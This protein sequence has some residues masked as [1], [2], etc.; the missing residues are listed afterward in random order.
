MVADGWTWKG[1]K[2]QI[3]IVTGLWC[4]CCILAL[5]YF[6]LT[7]K[8]QIEFKSLPMGR[9]TTAGA[10]SDPRT[11]SAVF[12]FEEFVPWE[13]R[14][15]LAASSTGRRRLPSLFSSS[16]KSKQWKPAPTLNGR[17]YVVGHV[18]QITNFRELEFE[19]LLQA[20]SP[21]KVISLASQ[22]RSGMTPS[23]A[24]PRTTMMTIPQGDTLDTPRPSI[25]N[26]PHSTPAKKGQ[27][28]E[29]RPEYTTSPSTK[30]LSRFRL[31][32]GIPVPS[33]GGGRKTGIAP[34][35]YSTV[36]FETRLA[37]YSDDEN[38]SGG[39][40]SGR[41]RSKDDAWVDIL[42]GQNK[43][44]AGQEAGFRQAGIWSDNVK[45]ISDPDLASQEVAQALAAVRALSSS[46]DD[47]GD[48]IVVEPT[49]DTDT[50]DEVESVPRA[51]VVSG[52]DRSYLD[53]ELDQEADSIIPHRQKTLGYFDLHPERRPARTSDDDDPRARL[54]ADSDEETDD[55]EIY[56][57]AEDARA[58]V[59]PSQSARYSSGPIIGD[60]HAP[61]L[62]TTNYRQIDIP[63][64]ENGDAWKAETGRDR[65]KSD[66][67]P[68]PLD[69][70]PS[71]VS[72]AATPSKTAALIEMYREKE[73]GGSKSPGPAPALQPSRLPVRTGSTPKEPTTTATVPLASLK[74]ASPSPSPAS[75]SQPAPSPTSVPVLDE[76]D[77]VTTEE[78]GRASPIRYV[79][80]APLHNVLEEEE[81]E[82]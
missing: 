39:E 33:P 32:G 20:S 5:E 46:T 80:G 70:S 51:S 43:R 72:K 25:D 81:E 17:P 79:H 28:N 82:V 1:E 45:G 4:A 12:L 75:P 6:R 66:S 23:M 44:K 63:E 16:S 3:G 61:S 59:L 77:H 35:E 15:Q 22:R 49:H 41:R 21:T 71:T 8:I 18:P 52:Y 69:A 62:I 9:T 27:S 7:L 64:Y 67:I 60:A 73:R 30:R 19:G 11:A 31:P 26:P 40:G 14:E 38:G 50:I 68:L 2:R 55:E 57:P 53:E 10:G 58:Q 13:Y 37:S 29:D 65:S 36:D 24:G 56:G 47:E 78:S 48:E 54:Q 42:V 34:S 76:S 74:I